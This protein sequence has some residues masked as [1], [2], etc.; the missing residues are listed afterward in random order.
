MQ[1]PPDTIYRSLFIQ[2]CGSL[3]RAWLGQLRRQS[4]SRRGRGCCSRP[5]DTR[6]N[7]SMRSRS[8]QRLGRCRRSRV[9]R[10]LGRRPAGR[11][12]GHIRG[13]P[14]RASVARRHARAPAQQGNAHRRSS[15]CS[16]NP[17][18]AEGADDVADV[19]SRERARRAS[20]IHD[21][22][23]SSGLLFVI[24][25]VRGSAGPTKT[26]TAFCANTCPTPLISPITARRA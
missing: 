10:P 9:A 4:Y 12:P 11:R 7:V 19:G 13:D 25:G 8:G 26:P 21:G 6:P 22:D 3:K 16:S 23:E 1:V 17:P 24:R 5:P 14:R 15:A 18:V 2:S 20:R